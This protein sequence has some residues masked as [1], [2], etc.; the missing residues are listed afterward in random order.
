MA[1]VLKKLPFD[2][3]RAI[4]WLLVITMATGVVEAVC[5][6][7]LGRVFAAY[8][9][10]T[11]ILT[12]IRIGGGTTT[13]SL[14]PAVVSLS[15][16]LAGALIGGRFVR[17]R[18]S[19]LRAFADTLVAETLLLVAASVVA[20]V[21][22]LGH[23][24]V[25]RYLTLGC[26]GVAMGT[27]VAATKYLGITDLT[28]P[29]ATGVIHGIFYESALA[30]GKPSRPRRRVG[31]VLALMTGAAVGAEVAHWHAWAA[32]LISALLILA[33]AFGARHLE[34]TEEDRP[35][36]TAAALP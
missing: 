11:L 22:P 20:A 2:E 5:Y 12:G 21:L 4:P 25:G 18:V 32:L 10:G 33:S 8:M 16:F 19:P 24:E 31:L 7:Q 27:Q 30:G 23:G 9:T 34:K 14:L 6:T 17:G 1:P 35:T 26:L 3:R 29:V 36:G 15:T 13:T 28:M